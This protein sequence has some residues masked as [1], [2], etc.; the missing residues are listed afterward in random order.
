MSVPGLGA[1]ASDTAMVPQEKDYTI[2]H[3]C[4]L[5][6]EDGN[7]QVLWPA[8]QFGNYGQMMSFLRQREGLLIDK[9]LLA[10][11]AYQRTHH[12]I[13]R[14]TNFPD[15]DPDADPV[16]LLL[17]G[18]NNPA[19]QKVMFC[20]TGLLNWDDNLVKVVPE[21]SKEVMEAVMAVVEL[22]GSDDPCKTTS[23]VASIP[24]ESE[25]RNETLAI[26]DSADKA[27]ATEEKEEEEEEIPKKP[28]AKRKH[29]E[30][31]QSETLTVSAKATNEMPAT[32]DDTDESMTA[33]EQEETPGQP[34]AKRSRSSGDFAARNKPSGAAAPAAL[35]KEAPAK[36]TN[37]TITLSEQEKT[38]EIQPVAK[39]TLFSNDTTAQ[40]ATSA[41]TVSVSKDSESV[42]SMTAI[43]HEESP[44]D[45][46]VQSER[47]KK[48]DASSGK[49]QQDEN[50]SMDETF[51]TASSEESMATCSEQEESPP[52]QQPKRKGRAP[53]KTVDAKSKG[54]RQIKTLNS[55][56]PT[57]KK[58]V[59]KKRKKT[60]PA[61]S[62]RKSATTATAETGP[63]KKK[64]RKEETVLETPEYSLTRNGANA[65]PSDSGS[66]PDAE[67]SPESS[68]QS[69]KTKMPAMIPDF[70]QEVFPLLAKV[71]LKCV[72]GKYFLQGV[73]PSDDGLVLDKDYFENVTRLRQYLCAYGIET[74]GFELSVHQQKTLMLW[75]ST[76][77]V[78]GLRG[79]KGEVKPELRTLLRGSQVHSML[80]RL[81]FKYRA[82]DAYYF[83][84]GEKP[85]VIGGLCMNGRKLIRD[86]LR[87]DDGLLMYL[88]RFGLPQSCTFNKL[89]DDERL[90]LEYHISQ[91]TRVDNL[92]VN[93]YDCFLV[94]KLTFTVAD[95]IY[96]SALTHRTRFKGEDSDPPLFSEVA[97]NS[98]QGTSNSQLQTKLAS[99]HSCRGSVSGATQVTN[100]T[101]EERDQ[102][103]TKGPEVH[104]NDDSDASSSMSRSPK[105][106]CE[107]DNPDD[108]IAAVLPVTQAEYDSSSEPGRGLFDDDTS[109]QNQ[110]SM[111]K[112]SNSLCVE[113]LCGGAAGEEKTSPQQPMKLFSDTPDKSASPTFE[114]ANE[115]VSNTETNKT[116]YSPPDPLFQ[117]QVNDMLGGPDSQRTPGGDAVLEI[118]NDTTSSEDASQT[119]EAEPQD[120][121]EGASP[122]VQRSKGSRFAASPIISINK[123]DDWNTVEAKMT[124]RLGWTYINGSGLDNVYYIAPD[125]KHPREGG[126]LGHDFV[127][128]LFG[129]KMYAYNHLGWGGDEAFF[130]ELRGMNS[131]RSSRRR[132]HEH[133]ALKSGPDSRKKSP[134]KR[135]P[136][137]R[138]ASGPKKAKASSVI[139]REQDRSEDNR[140]RAG[141]PEKKRTASKKLKA[142]QT[143]LS[144]SFNIN[145]LSATNDDEPTLFQKNV[146]S[147]NIFLHEAIDSNGAHGQEEGDPACLYVCGAPGVGK[148]TSIKW[149]IEE[150][151][152]HYSGDQV[153]Q[154]PSFCFVS[155]A[156]IASASSVIESIANA[157][158]MNPK[159]NSVENVRKTLV[160]GKKCS[161]LIMVIDEIELLLS[162]KSSTSD[163]PVTSG[164][165][166]LKMLGDWSAAQDVRFALIGISNSIGNQQA[167]RLQKFGLV[168]FSLSCCASLR[169]R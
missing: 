76:A 82:A 151:K 6:L 90:H 71:G 18:Y 128:E 122:V 129:L 121:S 79:L 106:A 54:R 138:P 88:A 146:N 149:S 3:A 100:I 169:L 101:E 36:D 140:L 22:L 17:G 123:N 107:E 23:A 116:P 25:N 104:P 167:K 154:C 51:F 4:F 30:S 119:G 9:A 78:P 65:S 143:A 66:S 72:R 99:P 61:D 166:A 74:Q 77:I 137:P 64:S 134:R 1:A 69:V 125:G 43:E 109:S 164:E 126:K 132:S 12:V 15:C 142:C 28:P 34:E 148:T 105:V 98:G 45:K 102:D 33:S 96:L 95:T 56:K 86:E 55:T 20:P 135:A 26:E 117:E 127:K 48:G 24:K 110:L 62:R 47:S 60:E 35:N 113:D 91:F 160:W 144:T 27:V 40:N 52:P 41:Q 39:R 75:M 83:L 46:D 136:T 7:D 84:P 10:S 118:I 153:P 163:K 108:L 50:E 131:P 29:G 152:R 13:N 89:T 53:K 156:D 114:E 11:L 81:G 111:D 115:D 139:P 58:K 57:R 21:A 70:H 112:K 92:Y 157:L 5:C 8:L 16:A 159:R 37:E 168:G 85:R 80:M 97:E 155:G 165:E 120:K 133:S 147:I 145:D 38:P 32:V 94:C 19:K 161:C 158:S 93:G 42:A 44:A 63:K 73:N 31:T 68:I 2:E 162:D 141:H 124:Q 59:P 130:N 103:E 49:G 87:N 150:A 67:S 14:K